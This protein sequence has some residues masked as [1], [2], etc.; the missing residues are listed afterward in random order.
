[1]K[2]YVNAK[3]QRVS[4]FYLLIILIILCVLNVVSCSTMPTCPSF[5]TK[6]PDFTLK[7]LDD[8]SVNLYKQSGKVVLI[9]FWQTTCPYCIK[10]MP[11]L[12]E[13]QDIYSDDSF[14][15]LAIN[16]RESIE[17]VKAYVEEGKYTLTFLIDKDAKTA[18]LYCVPAFPANL[19]VDKDGL[20]RA[21]KLGAFLSI[22]EI[23]QY[24]ASLSD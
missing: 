24:L 1:M 2:K 16:V 18:R 17:R 7:T 21:A 20:I 13:I 22:E 14:I 9:N 11:L 19:F 12:Q 3:S 15:V 6:A 23:E 8:V 4:Y 10:Q 5:N